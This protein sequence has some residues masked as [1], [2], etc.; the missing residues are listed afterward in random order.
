MFWLRSSACQVR[1]PS[2]ERYRPFFGTAASMNAYTTSGLE[3][4]IATAM[5]PHGLAG[6]PAALVGIAPQLAGD[7]DVHRVG[8][9]GVDQDLGDVLGVRQPHVGPVVAAVGGL[10]DAIADRHAVAHPRFPGADPDHLGVGG[11]DRDRPD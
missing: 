4:A 6:N 7:A 1:P 8:R 10:V 5:R 9:T 2:L 11:I 3:G